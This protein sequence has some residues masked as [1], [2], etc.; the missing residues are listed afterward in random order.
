MNFLAHLYLSGDNP[1]VRIGNFIADAVK[2]HDW[3]KYRDGIR[4]GIKLHRAIDTFTDNHPVV[5][6]SISRLQDKYHKYSGVIVDMLYDH[7]L[8]KY[9]DEY[10]SMELNQFVDSSYALMLRNFFVLPTRAKRVLSFMMMQ[11]W[12]VS[13][14]DLDALER[15][16]RNM[17][18]RTHFNS[19]MENAVVDIRA[20]Y[21]D[22]E[23]D[24]REFFPEIQ[25]YVTTWLAKA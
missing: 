9:W 8:A 11:N 14:A 23:R 4:T 1:D 17:S 18:R 20:S 24:F 12:L 10:N 2:G 22:F 6:N 21:D 25:I 5:R 15:H 3:E 16:Y 19:G 13:Y 7:Y